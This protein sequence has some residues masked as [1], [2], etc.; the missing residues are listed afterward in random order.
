M[1]WASGARVPEMLVPEAAGPSSSELTTVSSPEELVPVACENVVGANRLGHG[2]N[3]V[4]LTPKILPILPLSKKHVFAIP[5]D[6]LKDPIGN[7]S[8][9]WPTG[10][11][12]RMQGWESLC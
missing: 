7:V 11:P 1:E 5:Q 6:F 3:T 2:G 9:C 4:A 10:P 8:H 12:M